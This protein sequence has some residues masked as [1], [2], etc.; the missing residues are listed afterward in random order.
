MTLITQWA[1][2]GVMLGS[3]WLMGM[4]LDAYRVLARRFRLQGWVISLVDLLYWI[5]AAI[6]VFNLLL[7]SN[8]GEL[9]FTVFVAVVLGWVV[10]H[11][12]FS[13]ITTKG[14]QWLLKLV[15]YTIQMVIRIVVLTLW[16]PLVTMGRF[17]LRLIK[18][19]LRLL[20][21]VVRGVLWLLRPLFRP[22]GRLFT[23]L[24]RRIRKK[25]EPVWR[26]VVKAGKWVRNYLRKQGDDS[27]EKKE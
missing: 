7:W 26:P 17:L 11:F 22:L 25:T 1:T 18:G 15:E 4:L 21:A 14:I 20:W 8:W 9:R 12:W 5:A 13:N 16:V 19:L 6:L 3:G 23:P 24:G 27:D 2:M 10:Y